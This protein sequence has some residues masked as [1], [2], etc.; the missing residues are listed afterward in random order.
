MRIS[1]RAWE[2]EL[3]GVPGG[4]NRCRRMPD[5]AG[6]RAEDGKHERDRAGR[7]GPPWD[8][9]AHPAWR[10][11]DRQVGEE[12]VEFAV[13]PACVQRF[14]PFLKLVCAETPLGRRVP[15]LLGHLLP[16]GI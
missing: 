7:T 16:I 15:Q 14:E 2:P 11:A 8:S 6:E 1:E 10:A 9:D 13:R 12:R 5:A 3:S 4:S